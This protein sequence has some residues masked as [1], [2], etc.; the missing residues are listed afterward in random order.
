MDKKKILKYTIFFLTVLSAL[1]FWRAVDLAINFYDHSAWWLPISFFTLYFVSFSLCAIFIERKYVLLSISI[2][3]LLLSFA[4]TYSFWHLASI[5]VATLFLSWADKR[6]KT[7][8]LY[9][10]RI[11][12]WKSL[13]AGST[14]VVF[15][16]SLVIATFYYSET[17]SFAPD[18]L[19]PKLGSGSLASQ[20]TGKM[21]DLLF[22]SIRQA[23]GEMTVDQL[24]LANQDSQNSARD[25]I[26]QLQKPDELSSVDRAILE[27]KAQE[28]VKSNQQLILEQ[29]RKQ[30]SEIVGRDLN[31]SEKVSDVFT[32]L[33]N[34]KI[35]ETVVPKLSDKSLLPIVPIVMAILLFLTI[36]PIGTFLSPVWLGLVY[37][38]FIILIK[39]K[40]ANIVKVP[41]EIEMI[42]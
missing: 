27:S 31:G 24:I 19:I 10:V 38:I 8:L 9:A 18:R 20:L 30:L 12:I 17:R 41:A 34:K 26:D 14:L 35:E 33:V 2:L 11:N 1:L 13:R 23:N 6:I 22:P 29:S 32:D 42:E 28:L 15:A 37:L 5:A 3:T 21:I 36:F 4:F 39:T 16:L 40:V 25:I 7:D